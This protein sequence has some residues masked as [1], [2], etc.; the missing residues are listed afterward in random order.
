MQYHLSLP[1]LVLSDLRVKV[2]R[3][4]EVRKQLKMSLPMPVFLLP[5]LPVEV[6]AAL[7]PWV[8]YSLLFLLVKIEILLSIVHC[9]KIKM[10]KFVHRTIRRIFC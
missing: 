8:T 9:N 3:V 10:F 2:K 4:L 6:A 5:P 7:S 1:I